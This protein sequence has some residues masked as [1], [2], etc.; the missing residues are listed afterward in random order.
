MKLAEALTRK[1]YYQNKINEI[2]TRLKNNAIIPNN[3]IPEENPVDLLSELG[4][5]CGKIQDLSVRIAI[6]NSTNTDSDGR[7]ITQL[8]ASMKNLQTQISIIKKFL[9]DANE[10]TVKYIN[11]EVKIN[12]SLNIRTMQLQVKE[13]EE[14]LLN[15]TIK[16]G[17]LDS[18]TDLVS[19][20][21]ENKEE[22]N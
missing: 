14:E 1:K 22:R 16:V 2:Q 18:I 7:S 20:P 21:A 10:L 5:Y 3:D 15:L 19:S 13:L 4:E 9:N 11:S 17:Q 6:T 12:S 8:L